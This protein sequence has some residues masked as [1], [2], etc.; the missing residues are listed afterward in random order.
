MRKL[1]LISLVFPNPDLAD[2]TP[3]IFQTKVICEELPVSQTHA[4]GSS[5]N[6]GLLFD[7]HIRC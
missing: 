5:G 2:S 1:G 4:E 3:H 7:G 6:I